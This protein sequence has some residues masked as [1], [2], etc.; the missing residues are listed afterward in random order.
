M[1]RILAILGLASA[2]FL[3][4]CDDPSDTIPPRT[5]PEGF[6]PFYE[7]WDDG[8]FCLDSESEEFK[9]F[10][11]NLPTVDNE[12][13]QGFL[14]LYRMCD[15]FRDETGVVRSRCNEEVT[16]NHGGGLCPDFFAMRP[17]FH[18]AFTS[19]SGDANYCLEL[20]PNTP[21]RQLTCTN[22]TVNL[23]LVE[24]DL[25][26]TLFRRHGQGRCLPVEQCKFLEEREYPSREASC[27]Y[28]DFSQMNTGI[29]PEQDC[30]SL[31]EGECAINCACPADGVVSVPCNFL[32]EER[33]I[34]ICST[35]SATCADDSRC[36][37]DG[38]VCLRA[39]QNPTW[40]NEWVAGSNALREDAPMKLLTYVGTCVPRDLCEHWSGNSDG[41]FQCGDGE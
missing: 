5:A 34:G 1:S 6:E 39:V 12:T 28:G 22:G 15:Y 10:V 11:S 23:G 14:E 24:Y 26:A 40:I 7:C 21:P 3:A 37:D 38:D 27:F 41:F 13:V 16:L 31:Q 35:Q 2:C 20:L 25:G 36:F 17:F 18:A 30:A 32:S 29:I 19:R 33:P 8:E 9:E 4:A